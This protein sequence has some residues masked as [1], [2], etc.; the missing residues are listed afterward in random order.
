LAGV[1]IVAD[2]A[3]RTVN[4]VL[5]GPGRTGLRHLAEVLERAIAAGAEVE[6]FSLHQASLDDVF[7]QLTRRTKASGGI[8]EPN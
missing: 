3:R 5:G 1:V 7:F 2:R 6:A 8:K 4:V